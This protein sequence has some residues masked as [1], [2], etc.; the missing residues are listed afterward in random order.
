M[1]HQL[2]YLKDVEH[3]IVMNGGRIQIEGSYDEIKSSESYSLLRSFELDT[4]SFENDE[5]DEED[6]NKEVV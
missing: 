1:T 6:E 2:Q 5:N 3:I 4:Q